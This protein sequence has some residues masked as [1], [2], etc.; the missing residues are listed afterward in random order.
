MKYLLSILITLSLCG[1]SFAL[2]A[3]QLAQFLQIASWE[4]EVQLPANAFK[5]EVLEFSDG[6]VDKPVTPAYDPNV[7]LQDN[8]STDG[9]PLLVMWKPT[10]HG[11]LLTV[12]MGSPTPGINTRPGFP[13]AVQNFGGVFVRGKILKTIREGDYILGG[14]PLERNGTYRSTDDIKDYKRGLLLRISKKS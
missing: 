8:S 14:E 4:S 5:V 9:I 1:Q 6:K 11:L 2:T 7:T 13:G 3:D 10:E 12:T